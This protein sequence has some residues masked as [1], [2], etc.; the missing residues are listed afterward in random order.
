VY[1]Y[2]VEGE[3][4]NNVIQNSYLE[5]DYRTGGPGTISFINTVVIKTDGVDDDYIVGTAQADRLLGGRGSDILV[6]GAGDDYVWGGEEN[7]VLTGGAG[8]D[9]FVLDRLDSIDIIT[10]F[11]AGDGGDRLDLSILGARLGWRGDYLSNGDA[12]LVQSGSDVLLQLTADRVTVAVLQNADASSIV[13]ANIQQTISGNGSTY[14]SPPLPTVI[15]DPGS[16]AYAKGNTIVG[17]GGDV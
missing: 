11:E 3:A 14:T 16:I 5:Y 7:D 6:G 2:N 17:S 1:V 10:D 9:R 8:A 15:L 4:L 12:T 13:A